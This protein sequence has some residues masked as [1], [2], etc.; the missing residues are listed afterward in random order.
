MD[1]LKKMTK[2]EIEAYAKKEFGVDLHRGLSKENLIEH[3]EAMAS[4]EKSEKA[5][6]GVGAAPAPAPAKD[7][8]RVYKGEL[9]KS[10]LEAVVQ[11][12][13]IMVRRDGGT[14]S[15]GKL[16]CR[17]LTRSVGAHLTEE[18]STSDRDWCFAEARQ[19]SPKFLHDEIVAKAIWP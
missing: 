16:S 19:R 17:E 8:P 3:V 15:D 13:G 6:E 10:Q 5:K 11:C 14:G 4:K 12:V 7:G 9:T 2:V 1:D 18:L